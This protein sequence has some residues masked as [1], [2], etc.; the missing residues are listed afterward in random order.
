MT[1]ADL[2]LMCGVFGNISDEDIERTVGFCTQLCATG[3]TLV[4]TRH[5]KQ[6]DVFPKICDWFEKRG[7]VREWLS[8][9]GAGFGDGVH[10]FASEPAPLPVGARMFTFVGYDVLAQVARER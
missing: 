4:W 1:P 5:H 8:A 7:F 2:A 3:G 10:R 9:P 6:P